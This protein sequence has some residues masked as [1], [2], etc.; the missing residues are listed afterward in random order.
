MKTVNV[1]VFDPSLICTASP[2][3]GDNVF[4]RGLE[5]LEH[6]VNRFDY[7]ATSNSNQ[8]LLKFADEIKPDLFWFGK[9]ER[10]YPETI[11][12]LKF[13]CP[14][15][16][17][18]KWATDVR[19]KPT[20]FD[21]SHLEYMDLFTATYAG[22]YLKKH[23]EVMSKDSIAMSMMT[24]TDSNF[25]KQISYPDKY[26]VDVVW[27]GRS[28][29][30]DNFLRNQIIQRLTEMENDYNISMYG[31]KPNSWIGYPEYLH[32]ICGA[33]IGIG[34]NSFN[35]RKY[36]S[37]RLGNYM[38]CGTFYLTQYIE[39]LEECF[40]RGINLDW[41]NDLEEME[42]KIEYYLSHDTERKEIAKDGQKF[43]LDHFDAKP[44]VEN[45]LY[46]LNNKK[47]QYKWDEIY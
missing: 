40:T 44:L 41:F 9:C 6:D 12:A 43:I 35:R 10:I 30:G 31:I 24:F 5:L 42:D 21:L 29:F 26:K 36:S 23:K 15:S 39:G 11:R 22:D 4:A 25:Y 16:I 17:F 20:D 27:T 18:I 14:N 19:D 45:I 47:S 34:T 8:D 1:G 38:A 2:Y 28:G 13:K 33:K 46:T 37:D 7:R 3:C 32:A